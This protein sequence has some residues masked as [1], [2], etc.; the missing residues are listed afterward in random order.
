M[1]KPS[2][3]TLKRASFRPRP[4][5]R[6][7]APALRRETPSAP[8]G[9]E[10]PSGVVFRTP[11]ALLARP[12][13]PQTPLPASV[14]S[15]IREVENIPGASTPGRKLG[16][17]LQVL[18]ASVPPAVPGPARAP[19]PV[20]PDW[21]WRAEGRAAPPNRGHWRRRH[22]TRASEGSREE[23]TSQLGAERTRREQSVPRSGSLGRESW[24]SL[25]SVTVKAAQC[26][27][28]R[29]GE[30]WGSAEAR[31]R[32]WGPRRRCQGRN[33]ILPA[34]SVNKGWRSHQ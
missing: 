26:A 2:I 20:T 7:Q 27:R 15:P 13:E 5:S 11:A 14:S 32:P 1:R 23:A 24:T 25:S 9:S 29:G 16:L 12:A 18:P 30:R 28:S 3:T 22:S 21:W 34:L 19:A 6:A 10:G 33:R 31:A 8:L 17:D 4:R